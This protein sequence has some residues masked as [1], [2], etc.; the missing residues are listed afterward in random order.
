MQQ[1]RIEDYALLS[2][3]RSAALVSKNGSIDWL[4]VPRFDSGACF[5]ALLGGPEHG[6]WLLAPAEGVRSIERRYREGTL[7][8]ETDYET[9]DGAIRVIDCMPHSDDHATEVVRV[10]EGLRGR[11]PVRMELVIRFDYGSVIPWVERIEG[12]LSAIA[13]P[14][15]LQLRTRAELRSADFRTRADFSV[16]AGERMP[17]TLSYAPSYGR[18]HVPIDAD[19]A[20]EHSVDW[21]RQWSERCTYAGPWR[22]EVLR[23]VITLKALTYAPTGGIVAAPTTSLPEQLGGVR[24]WDY[25]F[26]WLRDATFT[27]YALLIAGYEEEARAWREWLL[28]AAAGR[29][30]D[31]QIL[32]GI[33]GERR[34]IEL[35][36][37]WLPGYEGATPVRTGNAAASQFQLD[38]YGEVMDVFHVARS[39]GLE[40]E[41]HAWAVQRA[42]MDFLESAWK[43]PDE[44]IWEVRGGRRHFT[45]SKVMAWVAAD[46]AVKAVER[47]GLNGPVDRWRRLRAEIH[48]EVCSEGFDADR[49]AFVQ[50]YGSKQLDAS[51]LMMALVGFLPAD[52]PRIRATVASIERELMIDGLVA[53]YSTATGVD[54]LP[55]GDGAFLA[56][57]FWLADNWCMQGRDAEA[58]ALFERLLA[59][60][61][62][63][64]L[65]SEEYDP[66]SKRMLGNFPQAFTHVALVNTARNL[67]RRGGPCE[68]RSGGHTGAR[69]DHDRSVE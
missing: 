17:F 5:A 49:G 63:V 24:N 34:L 18:T 21:W 28:R 56:C 13:G 25:R 51:V 53:R 52:D 3:C 69:A 31:L 37:P 59:L 22:D 48:E 15:S 19:R 58:C 55:P 66:Q 33:A 62:D 67:S 68:R 60:C 26:C 50:A 29:P 8:L 61:N 45:H 57:S 6:R 46:R 64:G 39:S 36:L 12:G 35:D 40:P 27:L 38:V 10:V 44:G 54:G 20:I 2:D 32:Y 1:R 4:C 43:E 16:A 30:A 42:L 11:V 9:A 7:V 41:T 47:F 23:S 14:D 65:I